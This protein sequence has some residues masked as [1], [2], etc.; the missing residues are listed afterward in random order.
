MPID[1]VCKMT[2]DESTPFKTELGG[3]MYYFCAQDCLQTFSSPEKQ[4]KSMKRRATI[5]LTGVLLIAFLRVVAL[6]ALAAGVSLISW[7]PLPQLPWF[8]WGYWLFILSTPIQFI[9]GW[10]FYQG[11]FTAI[12]A[13]RANM[14]FLIALGTST[15]YLYSVFILFFPGI[16]PV[17]EKNVY[18]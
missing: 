17:N 11:A 14:D 7:A 16:L 2:V 18:F 1:P 10:S 6:F 9:G 8:T 12:K 4:L 5:A 15:A 13:K 3:R